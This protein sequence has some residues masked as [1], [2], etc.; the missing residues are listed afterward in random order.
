MADETGLQ[1][2]YFTGERVSVRFDNKRRLGAVYGVPALAGKVVSLEGGSKHLEF[3]AETAP[4]RLKPGLP[5]RCP[6]CAC[7]ISRR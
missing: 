7:E 3:R 5:T 1:R 6:P 2:G 4:D